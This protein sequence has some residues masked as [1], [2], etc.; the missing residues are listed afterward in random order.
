MS[1]HFNICPVKGLDCIFKDCGYIIC[2]AEGFEM[3]GENTLTL[4]FMDVGKNH[5]CAFKVEDANAI[6]DFVNDSIKIN[7]SEFYICC[8]AGESRSPAIVAALLEAYN[9]DSGCIWNDNTYHPNMHV[10]E[11][12]K[13]ALK[14]REILK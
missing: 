6:I 11:V 13:E 5:P 12:M 10:Y 2:G 8:D 3:C 1:I 9:Q 4:N 14:S 7:I